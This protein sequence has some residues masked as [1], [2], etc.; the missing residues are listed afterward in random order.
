MVSPFRRWDHSH[1]KG[2]AMPS[3][4]TLTPP[5]GDP[6][7]FPVVPGLEVL[8]L[9]ARGGHGTVY[10]AHQQEH[11][12]LVALKVLDARFVDEDT[13][14]RFDRERTALGRISDHPSIVSL[15]D[16]GYT[17][18][19]EP[20]LLLEFAP[21][22]S[23]ADRLAAGPLSIDRATSLVIGL[24][25]AIERTHNAG[26][27]HRDIKPAN[28]MR[29]AY[30]TWMLTDFGIASLLDRSATNAVHASYAHTA[31]E[32]FGGEAP[33]PVA[34]VYSL[35]SVLATCLT[36]HEPFAMAPGEAAVSVMRRVAAEPY[37]DLRAAGVPDELAV[38]LEMALSKEPLQ[39]PVSARAFA[40]ALNAVRESLGLR[41]VAV[42]T[43]EE[44]APDPTV[45]V[46]DDDAA[47]VSGPSWS[48][49]SVAETAD[50]RR[51]HRGLRLVAVL[52]LF[53]VGLFAANSV[54]PEVVGD[55]VVDAAIGAVFDDGG[56]GGDGA[57]DGDGP[58]NGNGNGPGGG[59]GGGG[60]NGPGGGG[61][62]N[63][64]GNGNG[65][66]GNGGGGNGPGGN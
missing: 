34:D 57:D 12:R 17:S 21:G 27:V 30:D 32:T 38:L 50:G 18:A 9:V 59:G 10:R 51:T 33:S 65:P 31:P 37:P 29:S 52:G 6:S 47:A 64:N 48:N 1:L 7:S 35:A 5:A 8:E 28:I 49:R 45:L 16:S 63:G 41:A 62:G 25:A 56:P 53:V 40:V 42:R 20:Y 55:D 13:R 19:G 2:L 43:G 22:G 24:A 36:G 39:R 58:G 44:T 46:D 3:E 11:D 14:R 15:L 23:L 54:L 26:V 61:N 4:P 60:G 66:G